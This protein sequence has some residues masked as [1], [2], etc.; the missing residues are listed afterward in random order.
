[1]DSSEKYV[2]V[3]MAFLICFPLNFFG[4]SVTENYLWTCGSAVSAE[5]E[6]THK[7]ELLLWVFPP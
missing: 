7:N 5:I 6:I 1:M 3:I 4:K 2:S